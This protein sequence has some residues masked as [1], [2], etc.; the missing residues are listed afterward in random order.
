MQ[1]LSV[2]PASVLSLLLAW[3][4]FPVANANSY[5]VVTTPQQGTVWS[6]GIANN[7]AWT[8]GLL[9]GINVVDVEMSRL[10]VDGLTFIAKDVPAAS[11]SLNI[12]LQDIPPAD[13]YFLLFLNST[14]GVMYGS[15]PKFSIAAAGS[16]A[17][18]TSGSA[19][20]AA[21]TVTVSGSPNPTQVFATTFPPSANG[22]A[23]PG[24]KA[25]EGSRMQLLAMLSVMLISVLGG[26]WTVL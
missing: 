17:N 12:F 10:S 6:N 19:D 4:L 16:G 14:H 1:M 9:D 18:A 20:P 2:I 22:V 24:W 26:A 8:K 13:D 7:V 5:F 3:C 21:A 25:I 11:Q 15:S 23:V